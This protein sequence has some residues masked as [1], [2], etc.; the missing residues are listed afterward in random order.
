MEKH[1][2]TIV[3]GSIED[4]GPNGIAFSVVCCGDPKT[5]QRHTVAHAHTMTVD[6]LEQ[7]IVRKYLMPH[8]QAHKSS[9]AHAKH[10]ATMSIRFRQTP[11]GPDLT[12]CDNCK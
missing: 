1:Q 8:E 12:E 10:V 7:V 9:S 4:L 3:E 6:E 5:I 11:A 2:A